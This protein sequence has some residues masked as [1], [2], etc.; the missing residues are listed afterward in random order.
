MTALDGGHGGVLGYWEENREE[1][2]RQGERRGRLVVSR[3]RER[4][5]TRTFSWPGNRRWHSGNL[6]ASTQVLLQSNE[7]D[8]VLFAKSPWLRG[9]SQ[10]S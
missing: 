2:G 5:S 4:K 1:E 7:E 8:K 9:V 6:Q 10:G 3:W